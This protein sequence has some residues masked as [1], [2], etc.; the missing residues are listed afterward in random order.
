MSILHLFKVMGKIMD[1]FLVVLFVSSLLANGVG[2]LFIV[3]SLIRNLY[4]KQ[5]NTM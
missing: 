3:G 5:P 4:Q 2:F 1:Q